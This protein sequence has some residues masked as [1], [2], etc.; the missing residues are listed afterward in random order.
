M[1]YTAD[2]GLGYPQGQALISEGEHKLQ[3]LK[4][5]LGKLKM[6]GK[7]P[8]VN[9][10]CNKIRERSPTYRDTAA[11]MVLPELGQMLQPK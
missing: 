9:C 8:D 7:S 10:I 6:K 11:R 4:G 5:D 2:V 3:N 1:I